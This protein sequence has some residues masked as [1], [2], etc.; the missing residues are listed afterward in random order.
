MK[1]LIAGGGIGGLTAAL[2]LAA[3]GIK[4]EVLERAQAIRDIGARIQLSPNASRVPPAL[5]L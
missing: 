2:C 4:V 3:Q 5:R 1:A